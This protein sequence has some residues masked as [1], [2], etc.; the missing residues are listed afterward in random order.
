M[1]RLSPGVGDRKLSVTQFLLSRV[2][3][4]SGMLFVMGVVLVVV[5]LLE[6]SVRENW[7]WGARKVLLFSNAN[8]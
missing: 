6:H 5:L 1:E 4:S 7:A 3:L 8:P 2:T